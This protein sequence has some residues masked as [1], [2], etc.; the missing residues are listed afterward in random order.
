[1]WRVKMDTKIK[2]SFFPGLIYWNNIRIHL[3]IWESWFGPPPTWR[4]REPPL[5]QMLLIVIA[6][7]KTNPRHARLLWKQLLLVF[8]SGICAATA[9]LHNRSKSALPIEIAAA[10]Y[11]RYYIPQYNQLRVMS[12]LSPFSPAASNWLK[13]MQEFVQKCRN[14]SGPRKWVQYA[15]IWFPNQS[16]AHFWSNSTL[17]LYNIP[18]V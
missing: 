7:R 14:R 1:M 12:Q 15:D 11:P 3:N 4:R 17:G 16:I 6:K 18:Q 10:S 2:N 5:S 8:C 9:Q 13:W